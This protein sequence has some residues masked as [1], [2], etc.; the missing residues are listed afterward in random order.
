MHDEL[1]KNLF[2]RRYVPALSKPEGFDEEVRRISNGLLRVEW[3]MDLRTFRNGNPDAIKYLGPWGLGIDRWILEVVRPAEFF[4]KREDWEAEQTQAQL[5]AGRDVMGDYPSRG[6]W[7]MVMPLLVGPPKGRG[8]YIP[9]SEDV[10]EWIRFN[11]RYFEQNGPGAHS[12]A[13]IHRESLEAAEIEQQEGWQRANDEADKHAEYVNSH[14]HDLNK[15]TEYSFPSNA[16]T[17]ITD[18]AVIKS[19]ERQLRKQFDVN[20]NGH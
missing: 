1:D 18:P 6:M 3:G 19:A 5:A 13:Q 20:A 14:Y 12:S 4:G 2:S 7:V 15:T 11:H 8:E 16:S 10:L 17:L 9:C